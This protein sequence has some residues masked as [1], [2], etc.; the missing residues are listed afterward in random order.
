[1]IGSKTRARGLACAL[2][3]AV[4]AAALLLAATAGAQER[5]ELTLGQAIALGLENNGN[6]AIARTNTEA[7]EARLGQARGGFFPHLS[8]SG[9]YTRLDEAPY[10]DASSFASIFSPLMTPFE[11]LVEHG[12][13]DPSTLE[14]LSATS[15]PSKIYLGTR[16][17]YS[18]G[19]SARQPLFTGGALLS[20]YGAARHSTRAAKLDLRRS[21]DQTRYNVTQAYLGLVQAD[22][23]LDVMENAVDQMRSH[24]SDLEAMFQEG[25][26][27]ESDLMLARVRLSQAELARSSAAH[28]VKIA[29]TSLAF[30][31]GVDLGSE[32]F[33]LEGLEDMSFP[34]LGLEE[35]TD[36]ALKKR[37]DLLAAREM[38]GA[39]DNSVSLAR[40]GYLPQISVVGNYDW[41]RPNRNYEPEFY[42][43]WSMTVA[44]QMNVFDWGVT[45]NRVKEAK[46]G[47]LGA[48]RALDLAS[49][50]TRLEVKQSF[51]G[52]EDAIESL[53]IAEEGLDQARE[54]LRVTRESFRNGAATN[55]DVLDAETALTSAEMNRVAAL[56]GLRL[57]EAQLALATGMSD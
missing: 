57:S 55:S 47:Y 33:P 1:M 10:L 19:L 14:G 4:A 28:S 39:S 22:A 44:L 26:V 21:E 49:D 36:L 9:T 31:L 43:H 37:P 48:I 34:E 29:T 40:S 24:V 45:G 2:G 35:W 11:Y 7:A 56:A 30:V 15:G 17:V 5:L 41:D 46:S 42:H 6:L 51:L 38:V 18:I 32:I 25:M 54:S 52:R 13:L 3:L 23:S 12:Y 20:S 50:A 27:L 16:D 53:A 8:L